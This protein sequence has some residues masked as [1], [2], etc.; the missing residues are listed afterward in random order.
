MTR[1][2][3]T[4]LMLSFAALTISCSSEKAT[5]PEPQLQQPA[6]D[7]TAL[8]GV[9]VTA[10]SYTA[11]VG[12]TAKLTA[13]VSTKGEV[14]YTTEWSLSAGTSAATIDAKTGVLTAMAPGLA[15]PRACATAITGGQ[16]RTVCDETSIRIVDALAPAE[17]IKLAFVRNGSIFVSGSDRSNAVAL[18]PQAIWPSWS[19]DGTRIA[20]ARPAANE[21]TKWQLCIALENGS[22]IRCAT[23]SG[24]GIVLGKPS[25]S[26]D[27]SRISFSTFNYSCPNGQCG[28]LGG[29]FSSLLLL[30]T[31]TMQVEAVRTPSVTST[32]W[33]P[34]GSKI[35]ITIF[36]VGTFGRGAF[37]TVNPDGTGLAYLGAGLGTYSVAAASW[38]PDG[39]HFALSLENENACPWYCDTAIGIMNADGTQLKVLD[40]A[41]TCFLDAS[42]RAD[43][44]YIWGMP[45]WTRD[46]SGVAYTLT[47]GGECYVDY[48]VPCGTDVMVAGVDDGR[49]DVLMPSAGFVSSRQ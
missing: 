11:L 49:I 12:S 1:L 23:G 7:S 36:G 24:D 46:G 29:N 6:L 38:S 16:S 27:G 39:R 15:F 26:P 9:L 37:A 25:W 42:C 31:A 33:S 8:T 18:I 4:T 17:D 47:R 14:Q 41:H 30:N 40:K 10:S 48:Q 5:G 43:E 19:P 28:Q 20:F 2:I 34:D 13:M 45:E 3:S 21:L 32:S 35:A 44:A 22:D